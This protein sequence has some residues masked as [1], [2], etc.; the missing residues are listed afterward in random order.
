MSEVV[1]S[2][3]AEAL[4]QIGNENGTLEQLA[5]EL[6]VL[7]TI[8]DENEKLVAFLEHP[9]VNHDKKRQFVNDVFQGFS[10]NVLNTVKILTER[11]RIGS[12]P[13]II[14]Y[15]GRMVN[16]AKGIAEAKVYTVRQ[17]S[18]GE[19]EQLE[20]TFAKRF[21][22]QAIKLDTIVDPSIIGGLKLRLG[23]TI[24]DGTISGKLKRIERNIVTAD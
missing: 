13:A 2:R 1:A 5:E 10:E 19:K 6:R 15:F 20:I 9:R 23:N 3:Y 17:L 4:F 11:H 12:M 22:K 8:F 24:Y 7:K 16:D 21:N 14:D 18:E